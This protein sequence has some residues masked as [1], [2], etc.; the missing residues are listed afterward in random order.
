MPDRLDAAA[1]VDL[2]CAPGSFTGLDRDVVGTDPLSFDLKRP[3]AAQWAEARAAAPTS[4]AVVTGVGE[5]AGHRVVL[6]IG[7]FA[8]LAGTMGLAVGER[9]TRA[10]ELATRDGLPVIGMPAS[11]GTRMQ[12]GTWAFAQMLK[13]AAAITRFKDAGGVY[14]TWLRHPVTGGVLATWASLGHVTFAEPGALIALTGPRVAEQLT[15][16]RLPDGIQRAEHLAACGIVD[17]VV[18]PADLPARLA[19][20][21]AVMA[22]GEGPLPAA[23]PEAVAADDQIGPL[24]A[25]GPGLA[26]DR[27]PSGWAAVRASRATDRPGVHELLDDH[28]DRGFPLR[29]DLAEDDDGGCITRL[30][31]W[32]GRPV[33]VVAHDRL[34]GERGASLG[35]AGHRKARHAMRLAVE[36]GLPIVALIDTRGVRATV[37]DVE[38]GLGRE[39]ARTMSFMSAAPVPVVS[40]LVGEGCGAGAIVWLAANHVVAGAHAWL[41]PIAPE[42]ASSILF[43]TTERAADVAA[44]QAVGVTS[45]RAMGMVDR[46][47]DDRSPAGLEP[48]GAAVG[49]AL[50]AMADVPAATLVQHRRARL[51]GL[52]HQALTTA[53]RGT[54]TP[55]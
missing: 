45:L 54:G 8:F 38:G 19:D 7:E 16:Q 28:T 10:F 3:Y 47:V 15:G 30:C 6:V 50:D 1:L 43:R 32:E 27:V 9:V 26:G 53:D 55:G 14:L 42:G 46:I 49:E 23:D 25:L 35:A 12:E 51:R 39:V 31:R 11:G 44:S 22:P 36:L 40:V 29:G 21:L 5:V 24:A 2:L 20:A 41:A 13:V 17:E 52:A 37:S 33:A 34:V 18:S 48:L 4:E